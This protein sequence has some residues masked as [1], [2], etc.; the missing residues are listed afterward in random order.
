MR[1]LEG[2]IEQLKRTAGGH[3]KERLL[4]EKEVKKLQAQRD[5]KVG[6]SCRHRRTRRWVE[7]VFCAEGHKYDRCGGEEWGGEGRG[8]GQRTCLS[9][10]AS[11][12]RPSLPS[13]LPS[14]L[15]LL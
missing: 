13:L 5:K 9:D 14:G 2:E 15:T 1:A 11:L 8:E 7:A 4:K 12:A 10:K 3:A 6:G